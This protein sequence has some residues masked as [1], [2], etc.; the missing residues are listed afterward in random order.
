MSSDFELKETGPSPAAAPPYQILCLSGGGYRGLYTATVLEELEREAGKPLNQIFDLI[1]GTSIGGILAIGL[2][3]EIPAR[4]LRQSFEQNGAAIFPQFVT[5]KGRRIFP[6]L[7]LGR[8]MVR[9]RYSVEGLRSTI[10]AVFGHAPAIRNL[11]DLTKTKVIIASVDV[12]NSCPKLFGID[13]G[14]L[15]VPII[16]VA[17]A[18]SAAPT[19]F[20]EHRLNANIFVDGGLVANAPDLVALVDALRTEAL[21]Q[22]HMLSIGTVGG[23]GGEAARKPSKRGWL[24]RG[25]KLVDLTLAAQEKLSVNLAS[26]LLDENYVRLDANPSSAQM[27]AIGLDRI[28]VKASDTLKNLAQKTVEEAFDRD[29][30]KLRGMLNRTSK[31]YR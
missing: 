5:I 6:R 10:N 18:T 2:A 14:N 20:P 29:Q 24:M 11:S 30:V 7:R 8:G 16:D 17:L 13:A 25:K 31:H 15:S 23:S 3:A 9:S 1:A 28:D 12:T 22:I 26:T 27:K 21:Q 19:Y 4:T